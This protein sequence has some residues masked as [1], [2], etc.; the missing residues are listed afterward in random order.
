M[1][2]VSVITINFNNAIGLEKTIKS[3]INQSCH[4]YEYLIIDGGS[5]DGSLEVVKEYKSKINFW[6]SEPDQGIYNAMNIGT[7]KATGE[8]CIFLNSGDVFFNSQVLTRFVE[9]GFH[10][11]IIYGNCA[12]TSKAGLRVQKFPFPLTFYW[13][14]T[15]YLCHPATFIKRQL[16]EK[17]GYYN[18]GLKIVSDWEFFLLAIGK[19]NSSSF[20]LDITIAIIEKGGVSSS[21]VHQALV[22][23][24]RMEV[25]QKHFPCFYPDYLALYNYR[26]NTILKK[27]KRV[28]KKLIVWKRI[29]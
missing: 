15:E 26:H 24:E 23:T 2:K 16:F 13:L 25:M 5:T 29:G 8:Y 17:I 27:A 28:M 9:S 1:Q 6:Q 14:Y 18:E 19:Y 10:A 7:K 20:H 21:D 3:V 4:D 12:Y 11:D 22:K